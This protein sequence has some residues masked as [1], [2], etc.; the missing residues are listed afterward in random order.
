MK[1]S[2]IVTEQ[3]VTQQTWHGNA[4][5]MPERTSKKI[6]V[7]SLCA[8]IFAVVPAAT[9]LAM[10]ISGATVVVVTKLRQPV[11]LKAGVVQNT[12]QTNTTEGSVSGHEWR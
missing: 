9:A 5:K 6:R 7:L 12:Q 3:V 11:D 1:T 2:Q 10:V 8:L 4:F